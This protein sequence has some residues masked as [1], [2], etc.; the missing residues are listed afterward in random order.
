MLESLSRGRVDAM[1]ID[2]TYVKPLQDSGS[3]PNVE[4]L[5]VPKDVFVNESA[6]V[7]NT[8]ELRDKYNEW[9]TGIRADGTLA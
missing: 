6:S 1:L 2:A 5:W 9:L 7:F 8:K 4:F 3:Y